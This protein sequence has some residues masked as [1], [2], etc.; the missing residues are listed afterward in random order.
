MVWLPD[1]E[2]SLMICLAVSTQ[3]PRVK[4]IIMPRV[5]LPL[6]PVM[7]RAE[8]KL[9]R[10]RVFAFSAGPAARLFC[11]AATAHPVFGWR[12]PGGLDSAADGSSR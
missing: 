4:K 1:G 12:R 9:R 6:S 8:K 10:R 7:G 2:K 5:L 11:S 3:Y